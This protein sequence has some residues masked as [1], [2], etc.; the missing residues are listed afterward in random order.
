MITGR[1]NI[2]LKRQICNPV[3]WY[4]SLKLKE[5]DNSGVTISFD[6]ANDVSYNNVFLRDS[7]QSELSVNPYSK[8]KLFSTSQVTDDLKILQPPT[9]ENDNKG[10]E[11]LKITWNQN[12]KDHVS[13]YPKSFLLKYSN[14]SNCRTGKFFE[15]DVSLWQNKQLVENIG[16]LQFDYFSYLKDDQFNTSLKVLNKYGLLFVNN[17]PEIGLEEMNEDNAMEWPVATLASKFGYIKKTFYGTL[18]NVKLEKEAKNIANT[19]DF[20]PLHMDLLYYESP[21]GLQ[22]LHFLKNSTI[23]GENIFS[24]SFAAAEF[25]KQEDPV[26]YEALKKIP[27]TYHYDNN[28][29]HY[30]Y[31][32]PLVVEEN[33]YSPSKGNLGIIKEV[34]YSPPFQGPFEIGVSQSTLGKSEIEDYNSKLFNEFLRGLK[35]FESYVNDPKNQYILKMNEGS[36]VIFN[37][38]RIL[39]S[40]NNFNNSN[41]GERWLMGCYV[42]GDSYRSKLRLS[43]RST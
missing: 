18:F 15:I 23:G 31:S 28:N 9:I 39:H 35:M 34:N 19:N 13:R 24:D 26:A 10:E 16:K 25:V 27:I 29:E 41:N 8:Q 14:Q 1:I 20:L 5:Y 38:R 7:C 40:R 42:D 4:S 37:N 2:G 21:P 33:V 3:R 43:Y 12:G 30:Y 32:R 6:G 11:W 17:I 36:C 22:L